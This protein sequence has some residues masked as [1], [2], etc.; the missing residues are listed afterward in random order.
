M[1]RPDV[2]ESRCREERGRMTEEL[3]AAA[4]REK[5][6][7]STQTQAHKQGSFQN[8]QLL[9]DQLRIC[10]IAVVYLIN[11]I[12]TKHI[13]TFRGVLKAVVLSLS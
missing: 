11:N 2:V 6:L 10:N 12:H 1:V 3:T 13:Q 9:M 4:C 8:I 5:H 7:H